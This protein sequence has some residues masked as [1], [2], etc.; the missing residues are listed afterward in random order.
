MAVRQQRTSTLENR[1][2]TEI[3]TPIPDLRRW[4][5]ILARYRDPSRTRSVLEL[6]ITVVPLV[7]LWIAMLVAVN[8]G[9]LFCLLLAVPAAGF[10]V[11]LFMIQHDCSHGAFFSHRLANDWIGRAIG[12]V[13]MTPYDLWRRTHALHHATSGNLD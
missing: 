9:C 10:L 4:T 2:A 5:Q 11:R 7:L 8:F 6:V 3:A 1:T 13:T 12:V